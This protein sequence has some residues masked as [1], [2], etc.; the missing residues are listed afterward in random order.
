MYCFDPRQYSTTDQVFLRKG[1]GGEKTGRHRASFVLDSV[2]DLKRRLRKIDSDL[3]IA[4]GQPEQ[5]LPKLLGPGQSLVVA[6]EEVAYE[7]Q[8]VERAVARAVRGAGGQLELLPAPALYSLDDVKAQFGPGLESMPDVFTPFKNALE[9]NCPLPPPLP[10]PLAGQLPLPADTSQLDLGFAPSLQQLP[11][12]T[13]PPEPAGEGGGPS[14]FS[15]RGGETTALARVEEYLFETD[16]VATYFDTRNGMLGRDYSTKFAPWLSCGALSPRYIQARIAEYERTRT[17]NKST[18]W[19]RFELTW[20]DY[21]R[22]M[23]IKHGSKI[24][25]PY[26]L[27]PPAKAP[28]WREDEAAL[29]RWKQ[30]RTGLPLVDAN[31]RELAATGWMSNRGRQNVASY[32]VHDLGIDWRQGAE[33]FETHLLD[34]DCASNWGNWMAAAGLTGGRINRFNITK[35]SRD[36]DA[37]GDYLRAWLPELAQVPTELIHTPWQMSHAVQQQTVRPNPN[38]LLA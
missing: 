36:Y 4:I 13:A 22:F 35:Q 17:E 10:A 29:A 23:A 20:R 38:P 5:V 27:L 18:Y 34:F 15:W 14:A 28:Q 3:L 37:Q 31:M 12:A 9:R 26:G 24:F 8:A 32:L 16:A 21:F 1:F 33:F 19:V 7:E 30:G 11:W 2:L 6:T 25:Q